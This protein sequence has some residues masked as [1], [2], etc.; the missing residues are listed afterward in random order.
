M[1]SSTGRIVSTGIAISAKLMPMLLR[2]T[3][4]AECMFLTNGSAKQS[5][6]LG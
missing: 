3:L 1:P 5:G 2:L 4:G 6:K